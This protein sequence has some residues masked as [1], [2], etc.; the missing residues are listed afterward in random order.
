MKTLQAEIALMAWL[1][2]SRNIVV[3]NLTKGSHL[4]KFETD[5]LSLTKSGY[6][7]G[8]EIKVS[9]SDLKNDLKKAHIKRVE[10]KSNNSVLH[11]YYK[12]LKY[13]YYAVPKELK[14]E[15]LKQ[16]P[17]F[18]GLLVL[19]KK[20]VMRGVTN[21]FVSVSLVR[22][23]KKLFNKKWTDTMVYDLIRIG[24]MRI[25]NLKKNLLKQK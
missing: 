15:A 1:D 14:D 11:R 19:E 17:S 7:T 18:C 16:I 25:F 4:V 21:D 3:P 12:N 5:L 20:R 9:K 10:Y 23:P 13:F 2:Y 22:K 24:T 6:A 8:V